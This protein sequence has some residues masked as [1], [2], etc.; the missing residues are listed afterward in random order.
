M[1]PSES[2][3]A[4]DNAPVRLPACQSCYTKKAKCDDARPKCNPCMRSGIDCL[5]VPVSDDDAPVSREQTYKLEQQIA[6][7]KALL[8][9]FEQQSKE[10]RGATLPANTV[11]P[12]GIRFMS[13]LFMDPEWRERYPNIVQQWSIA[14]AVAEISV[15]PN[16]L[17]PPDEALAVFDNYLNGSHV[18]NPFLLRR[19][20]QQLYHLVFETGREC[21][22]AQERMGLSDHDM[23]RTF[24]ILAIGSIPLYRTGAHKSHPYGYFRT[25]M[26]YMDATV[27]SR[28]LESIQDLLLVVRFGIYYH[29]GT[30]IWAITTLCMRMCIEQG[31][32]RPPR[33]SER[34]RLSLL[35]EQLQRRVFWECYMIGRYSSIILDRPHALADDDIK[36][37]FPADA[38]DEDI[39]AAET[40]GL[41]PDLDSF[42]ASST[43]SGSPVHTEITVFLLCLRL[44]QITSKIQ[45]RF[46]QRT[47]SS[48][49][50]SDQ[51]SIMESITARGRI[52]ADLDELLSELNDWRR[53]APTFTNPKCLFET[54][55][56]YDLLLMRERLILIRKVI[57]LYAVGTIMAFCPLFEGRAITYTRSYFQMLFTAG[58]S[59]MFCISVA[60][61][62]DS[63][64]T[65]NAAHALEQCAKVLKIM[66]RE[67]PEASHNVTMYESLRSRVLSNRATVTGSANSHNQHANQETLDHQAQTSH[68]RPHTQNQPLLPNIHWP[69]LPNESVC[70]DTLL[71][72][73]LPLQDWLSW[74]MWDVW[75]I[76]DKSGRHSSWNLE[77]G[78]G[79][80]TFSDP[81][82]LG[83]TE[84]LGSMH[85]GPA[86]LFTPFST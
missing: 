66:G 17:P 44:R 24:M 3:S 54:Q 52:Y 71:G 81:P 38:N 46:Q 31:Y 70:Q 73:D 7:N 85:P 10:T 74:D 33:P 51:D 77:D 34:S 8:E 27:L 37:G 25:A 86:S 36:I 12:V 18:Q 45:T 9:G 65:A 59:I 22:T 13:Y 67:I 5:T 35:Q 47:D 1:S 80:Y 78:T 68:S 14:S 2:M 30:S 6:R 26:K 21:P 75:D 41:N 64:T 62:H 19:D 72:D 29:I 69:S 4:Q 11:G 43:T 32:H 49:G 20:V 23:F 56:W 84:V 76:W 50:G 48:S 63:E 15:E 39:E 79:E 82:F 16:P 42:C 28:G 53:S 60:T 40:A 55:D 83:P 58:L 61:D 57:D